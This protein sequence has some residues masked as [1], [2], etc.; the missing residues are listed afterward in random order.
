MALLLVIYRHPADAATPLEPLFSVTDQT[1]VRSIL[2]HLYRFQRRCVC[3]GKPFVA[4]DG[5]QRYCPPPA[6]I[7][8]S[9]CG[10]RWRQRQFRRRR[11]A[12]ADV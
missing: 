5:R 11:A 12:R 1:I 8:E 7:K 9:L 4:R 6:G 2:S 3:C 10:N